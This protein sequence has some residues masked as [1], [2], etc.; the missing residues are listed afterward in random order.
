[1][2]DKLDLIQLL[3]DKDQLEDSVEETETEVSVEEMVDSVEEMV[4]SVVTADSEEIE[5]ITEI[6]EIQL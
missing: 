1:M 6:Q 3:K 4:D 5:V 2:V